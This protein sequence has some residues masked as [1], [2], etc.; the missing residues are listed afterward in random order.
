AARRTSK[1]TAIGR[2]RRMIR[3]SVAEDTL[4]HTCSD[5]AAPEQN[6]PVDDSHRHPVRIEEERRTQ[7]QPRKTFKASETSNARARERLL[8]SS[9]AAFLHR[10]VGPLRRP[11]VVGTRPNDL[12]VRELLED[13]GTPA[14]DAAGREDAGEQF[15]RNAQVVL[16]ARRVEIDVAVLADR[17]DDEPLHLDRHVVPTSVILL[18][19]KALG[20]PLQVLGT[21]VDRLIDRVTKAHKLTLLCPRLL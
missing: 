2:V 1:V 19:A 21:R 16:H 3:A 7:W 9:A 20:E 11:D 8:S 18:L 4:Q 15:L 6:R 14:R 13:V 17:G 5:R 12:V 10:Q